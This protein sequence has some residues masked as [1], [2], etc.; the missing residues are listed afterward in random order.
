MSDPTFTEPEKAT[1][2]D[3]EWDVIHWQR[4]RERERNQ[5]EWGV[6]NFKSI[7]K[8]QMMMCANERYEFFWNVHEVDYKASQN[9]N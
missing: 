9:K 6:P 4:E 5:E 3:H 7:L 1:S 8:E 2:H